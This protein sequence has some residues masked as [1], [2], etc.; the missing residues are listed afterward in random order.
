MR[1]VLAR[2]P[3]KLTV[4]IVYLQGVTAELPRILAKLPWKILNDGV[5][6]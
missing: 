1:K 6:F 3:V 4:E 5:T 2:G